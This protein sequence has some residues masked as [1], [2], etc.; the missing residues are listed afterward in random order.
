MNEP[1]GIVPTAVYTREQVC[2]V[3]GIGD[4][5]LRELVKKNALHPFAFTATWR[6]FGED[7]LRLCR[8]A[9]EGSK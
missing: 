5:K 6:F 3:L 2:C 9:S 4:T 8:L 1:Q 7:L